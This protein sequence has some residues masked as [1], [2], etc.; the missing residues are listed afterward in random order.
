MKVAFVDTDVMLDYLLK[1]EPFFESALK[2]M[3]AGATGRVRLL[4][5]I[6]TVSN[7]IYFLERKFTVKETQQKLR[8]LK[9]FI[10]IAASGNPETESMLN[11]SFSDLEDA[12][13]HAIAVTSK[14]DALITRNVKDYKY[15]TVAI[16]DCDA[17][18]KSLK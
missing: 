10:E 7:L 14:A 8:V 15:A 5:S 1:R 11:S 13:Q 3:N 12:L 18:L 9:T 17:F 16:M 4:I 6:I 2:L